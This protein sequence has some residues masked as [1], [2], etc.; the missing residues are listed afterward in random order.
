MLCQLL[1]RIRANDKP[2][3]QK[4][5]PQFSVLAAKHNILPIEGVICLIFRHIGKVSIGAFLQ[6]NKACVNRFNLLCL[7]SASGSANA[8]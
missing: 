4:N 7:L 1:F 8:T 5:P 2:Q 3:N 6:C